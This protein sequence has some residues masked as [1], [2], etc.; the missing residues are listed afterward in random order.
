[1]IGPE[2]IEETKPI[3]TK[4]EWVDR[5]NSVKLSK[6]DLNKLVMNF[7]LIE[8]YKDAAE[9]FK[10]ESGTDISN[11]DLTFMQER[12]DIRSMI[13][14]GHIEKA[15]QKVKDLDPRILES[16]PDLF[17]TMMLQKLIE[18]IKQ[19]RIL[20]SIDF[21]QKELTPFVEKNPKQLEKVEKVMT[22]LAFEDISGSSFS[23][24]V[25][26]SQKVK[27]ASEVNHQLLR[28]QSKDTDSKISTLIKMLLW[29]QNR[30]KSVVNF[31]SITNLTTSEF[32]TEV[33]E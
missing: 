19:N 5:L 24:L 23:D 17:F 12:L 7:F 20:E 2:D 29:S 30:L 21:A 31:P 4:K 33:Q 18:L 22:L 10:K 6:Q 9:N 8:G 13:H 28:S 11:M 16:N 27:V 32:S 1:M 14:D 15:I 26:N 3:I 25:E